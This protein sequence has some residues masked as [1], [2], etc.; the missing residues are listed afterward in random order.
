[1]ASLTAGMNGPADAVKAHTAA[2]QL[3][4]LL[5]WRGLTRL[6]HQH[7]LQT[8]AVALAADG[9]ACAIAADKLDV[10]VEAVEQGRGVLWT[11]L[12]DTRTDLTAL[13]RAAP[14]LTRRLLDCRTAL[15]QPA[16]YVAPLD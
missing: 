8:H 10:A 15:E 7:L 1:L 13:Q 3:L 6:D 4:P 5:A 11:Q 9:L 2:L 16:T 12:L 14:D